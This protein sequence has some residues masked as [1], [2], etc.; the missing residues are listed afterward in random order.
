MEC[1]IATNNQ[2]LQSLDCG[3]RCEYRGSLQPLC[4]FPHTEASWSCSSS[5]PLRKDKLT[6]QVACFSPSAADLRGSAAVM[7]YIARPLPQEKALEK[8]AP[9]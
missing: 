1:Q 7:L 4:I 9:L 5:L 8:K 3:S 2:V 6:S